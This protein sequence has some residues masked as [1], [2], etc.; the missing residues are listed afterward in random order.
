MRGAQA[1][2][3]VFSPMSPPMS[4]PHSS[5]PAALIDGADALE[6]GLAALAARDPVMARL[7]EDG[8]RPTLRAREPG[9]GGLA[10]IIVSQQVST[11]S[12][13]AIWGR[14]VQ[15]LPL[16]SPAALMAAGDADLRA[17][18]LSA[19]KIRTLRA[20]AAAVAENHLP[21][22]A[23]AAHPA[24][25]AHRLMVAVKGIGPWTADIYL[26]FCLGHADA[27]P[28]G[29]LALQ[30]AARLAYGLEARPS[31]RALVALAERWRPWRGVAA[32][33]LWA[34]YN[35]ARQARPRPAPAET[36]AG[37]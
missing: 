5:P 28:A 14:V 30:E 12:A 27:F 23:L 25:E 1:R 20:V 15:L 37:G 36:A 21:L 6:C 29:D 26:L 17:A 32:H 2:A 8:A 3:Q 22:D 9:L 11:A 24:D 10:R 4:P 7:M 35:Q 18:G 31:A 34:A 33:V 13:A 19:P 16:P